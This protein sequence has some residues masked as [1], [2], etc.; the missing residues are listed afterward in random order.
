MTKL[1]LSVQATAY[2][3]VA[4][5]SDLAVA[6][7]LRRDNPARSPVI[8]PPHPEPAERKPCTAARIWLVHDE[9][10]APYRPVVSA[11]AAPGLRQGEAPALAEEDFDFDALKVHIRRQLLYSGGQHVFKLPKEGRTRTAPLARGLAAIIKAH[12]AEHPPQPYEL[13]WMGEDGEIADDLHS[14]RLLYRWQGNDR[15]THGRHVNADRMS[16]SI[17]K[18]G[19]N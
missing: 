19:R 11:A 3:I 14:C 1:S 10:P 6:D 4:G 5:T 8:T 15:R 13:P 16:D 12:I 18:P 2:L 7:G 17:W 9:V